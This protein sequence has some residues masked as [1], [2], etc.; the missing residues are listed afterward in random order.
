MKG[1]CGPIEVVCAQ[2]WFMRSKAQRSLTG[3]ICVIP[4]KTKSWLPIWP[5]VCSTRPAGARPSPPLFS[6][7]HAVGGI[8][9]V[10]L[11]KPGS[12]AHTC[13]KKAQSP[14]GCWPRGM[15]M[16]AKGLPV[17]FMGRL[18]PPYMM[19]PIWYGVQ[20]KPMRGMG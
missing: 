12:S 11:A 17:A 18:R 10:A 1:G 16:H 5:A 6:M 15:K 19:A 4:P 7:T 8:T 2:A 3:P 9:P 13:E 20:E 14:S